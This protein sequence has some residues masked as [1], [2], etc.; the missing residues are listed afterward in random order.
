MDMSPWRMV[1]LVEHDVGSPCGVQ[2]A[3]ATVRLTKRRVL[4]HSNGRCSVS[5]LTSGTLLAMGPAMGQESFTFIK[6]IQ[7][8]TNTL[9]LHH[10]AT[11]QIIISS[12]VITSNSHIITILLY[13]RILWAAL[14]S[15]NVGW[16]M[17]VIL[18]GNSYILHLSNH[19]GTNKK[20]HRQMLEQGRLGLLNTEHVWYYT[21]LLWS[22]PSDG[23][24][25][26]YWVQQESLVAK[27]GEGY[28]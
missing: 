23:F 22:L 24:V 7:T 21:I 16:M 13:Y 25:S 18:L 15:V 28:S 3:P 26:Q 8:H 20:S 9:H 14:H 6:I 4:G 11:I 10:P 19:E 5:R 27:P 2:W 1:S 12:G 17:I